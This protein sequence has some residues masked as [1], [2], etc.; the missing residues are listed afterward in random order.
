MKTTNEGF[1]V[2]TLRRMPRH[3]VKALAAGAL[4]IAAALPLAVASSA[5][6][7][8]APTLSSV[9]AFATAAGTGAQTAGDSFGAGA[10]GT[11][12]FTGTGFAHDGGNVTVTTN[13]TGV[14]FSSAAE[15][16]ATAGTAHFSSTTAVAPGSYSVTVTD[17]NGTSNTVSNAFTVI[18]DPTVASVAPITPA[19]LPDSTPATATSVTVSG[20]GF[21]A[22]AD[23]GATDSSAVPAVYLTSTVNGTTLTTGTVTATATS[24]TFNVT[25]TNSVTNNPATPGTYTLTVVN[26]DGG[27]VTSGPIFT[28]TA[29]GITDVSPSAVP[30]NTSG[31]VVDQFLT[32][33]GTG[34]EYGANISITADASAPTGLSIVTAGTT[35]TSATTISLEIAEATSATQGRWDITVA[36]TQSGGNGATYVL[37]NGLGVGEASAIAPVVS[38]ATTSAALTAGSVPATLTLTGTGFSQ[39]STVSLFVG[40]GTTASTVVTAPYVAGN[41]GT[42][43]T[44]SV[45]A[46][47]NAVAGP[48]SVKVLNN[49]TGSNQFPAALTVNGPVIA[50]QTPLVAG[51][52]VG[53]T[54]TL[55]GTGFQN[56]DTG[57]FTAG[58][59][60]L[61]GIISYVNATTI[62]FVVTTSPSSGDITTAPTETVVQTVGG[63]TTDS[64]AFKLI[65]SPAPT[66]S[67]LTYSTAPV[68]DVGVG[69]VTDPI[70]ITGT[71]FGTGVTIGSFVNGGGIAD[72]D[73]TA[74]VTGINAAG[75]VISAT[76]TITPGDTNIADGYTITNTNGGVVKVSAVSTTSELLIGAGPTITSVTPASSPA[77][78]TTAFTIVGTNFESGAV[79][80]ATADG[81]CGTATPTNATT[82]TVSCT[83]GAAT[84]TAAALQVIN[85]DNGTATSA[86][87]IPAATAPV[88]PAPHATGEAGNP[89]V[90]KTTAIAV[91]GVGFY[92]QPK[93]TS[94]GASVKA[95]VSKDTGTLLTVLV[96]V[97]ATT[98]PGEHTLTFTLADGKVF[99]VNY[100]I[101][102]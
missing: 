61:A 3:G 72:P 37:T 80:A 65:V 63:V 39:Y 29:Y 50:S 97:G 20:G 33:T 46:A 51:A 93:V 10:T 47:T 14:T 99:K 6:A 76:V 9:Q 17:D 44:A 90:G 92:G 21:E 35:V 85:P 64:P 74:A 30:L 62:D 22:T 87:I 89:V 73:V 7:T 86:T 70:T 43:L 55:T 5:G 45:S 38:A 41:T 67:S 58:G 2:N 69:A 48:Y 42:T 59:G 100:L 102:K 19:S 88:A 81:T 52:P 18:A 54:V 101:V 13:A 8:T 82:L 1:L 95:V 79:V 98:G 34:F 96:T 26:Q 66:V 36:N 77:S 15:S 24:L 53:T 27:S 84:T 94:T 12:T 71:N 31:S 32:V 56:I 91:G 49:G 23:T 68:N 40:T 57:S 83:F 78:T 75:T 16:S 25:P 4:L 11:F 28:I 60:S